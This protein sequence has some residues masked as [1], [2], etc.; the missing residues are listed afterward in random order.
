MSY[1]TPTAQAMLDM[2]AT[3]LNKDWQ[4][5]QTFYRFQEHRKLYPFADPPDSFSP[6]PDQLAA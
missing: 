1:L 3:L 5:F 2:R 6:L 4:D